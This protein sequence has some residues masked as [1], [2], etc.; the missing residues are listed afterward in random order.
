[1]EAFRAAFNPMLHASLGC[2]K[3]ENFSLQKSDAL[4]LEEK[5][6]RPFHYLREC[7]HSLGN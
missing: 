7:K 4:L 1:M 2:K 3:Q 5:A 6:G